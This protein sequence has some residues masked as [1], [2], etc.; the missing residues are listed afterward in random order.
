M[1]KSGWGVKENKKEPERE[2]VFES[3]NDVL[4]YVWLE[5]PFILFQSD[6]FIAFDCTQYGY[7]GGWNRWPSL[8]Q[9]RIDLFAWKCYDRLSF[10][11]HFLLSNWLRFHSKHLPQWQWYI[12]CPPTN[13]HTVS[14]LYK[15]LSFTSLSSVS[16]SFV[17]TLISPF[18]RSF[19]LSFSHPIPC[20]LSLSSLSFS[21][22]QL[23]LHC[24]FLFLCLTLYFSFSF[25]PFSPF[26]VFFS[27][28]FF[29]LLYLFIP[30][31]SLL[32]SFVDP[33]DTGV[34]N[35]GTSWKNEVSTYL[36]CP[37]RFVFW[38][39]T[40]FCELAWLQFVCL[41]FCLFDS[42]YYQTMTEY[43]S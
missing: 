31:T 3:S 8:D 28:F 38:A 37:A 5:R 10:N 41:S 18:S 9:D 40:L 26:S 33:T 22:L 2:V 42:L 30:W 29:F 39:L 34:Q 1:E 11:T 19:I 4:K 6:Y 32:R 17:L 20:S 7:F 36:I 21:I 15:S 27:S 16:H 14:S 25:T 24:L 23:P 43:Q 12:Y 13:C 35:W